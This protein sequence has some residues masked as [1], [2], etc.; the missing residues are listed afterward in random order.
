[1][2]VLLPLEGQTPGASYRYSA[3]GEEKVVGDVPNPWRFASKRTEETGLVNFGR[4]FYVPTLGRWLS[5]DPEGFHDGMNLYAYVHNA[6]LTHFDE[7][8]LFSAPICYT[9]YQEP[10]ENDKRMGRQ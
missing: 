9:P 2:T 3:F 10:P 1:M 6:P 5:R 7:Y 8:G 4:R